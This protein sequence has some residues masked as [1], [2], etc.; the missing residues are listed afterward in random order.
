M[1]ER[2]LTTETIAEKI[3]NIWPNEVNCIY[4]PDMHSEKLVIRLRFLKSEEE[5]SYDPPEDQNVKDVKSSNE[6]A[7]KLV[8]LE[9]QLELA[10]KVGK[11]DISAHLEKEAKESLVLQGDVEND[12]NEEDEPQVYRQEVR[13]HGFVRLKNIEKSLLEMLPISGVIGIDKVF[14]DKKKSQL[15]GTARY[16]DDNGFDAAAEEWYLETEGSNLLCVLGHEGVDH[17]RTICNDVVEVYNTLGIE[18]VRAL[19]IEDIRSILKMY[20][21]NVNYRHISILADA[22]TSRGSLISMTRHGVN[23]TE[24]GPLMRASFEQTVDVLKNAAA[25]AMPDNMNGVTQAVMLG[26]TAPIGTGYFELLIDEHCLEEVPPTIEDNFGASL[27]PHHKVA[28]APVAPFFRETSLLTNKPES[29]V[30]EA[31][32]AETNLNQKP[33]QTGNLLHV[34]RPNYAP[35]SPKKKERQEHPFTAK[36]ADFSVSTKLTSI[37]SFAPTSPGRRMIDDDKG[38]GEVYDSPKSSFDSTQKQ[39]SPS[40]PAYSPVAR[41]SPSSPAYS[42][43]SPDFAQ[44]TVY[45]PSSPAYSPSAPAYSPSAPVYSPPRQYG[46]NVDDKNDMFSPLPEIIANYAVDDDELYAG[47]DEEYKDE[48]DDESKN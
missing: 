15:L 1:L 13:N 14:K 7:R 44:R 26:Q 34:T 31:P 28:G 8:S 38:K 6:G 37:P 35:S 41:Y 16:N 45:S 39:Y 22:I 9:E 4:T 42:P 3:A 12:V 36:R 11:I 10:V 5:Y 48:E 2:R 23:R 47:R 21:L 32:T 43:S 20:G 40:S 33:L 17:T 19:I 18:A 30:A 46:T 24:K 25:F 29:I 27:I